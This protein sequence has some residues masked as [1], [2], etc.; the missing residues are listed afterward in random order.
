M[1]LFG[2]LGRAVP[3]PARVCHRAILSVW[4][5]VRV[6]RPMA[7]VWQGWQIA[8]HCTMSGILRC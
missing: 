3:Q 5:E 1:C 6:A 8:Y 2:L 4:Q 7:Q